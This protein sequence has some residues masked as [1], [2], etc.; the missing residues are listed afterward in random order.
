MFVFNV[1]F[2]K[3]NVFNQSCEQLNRKK[4]TWNKFVNKKY[5]KTHFYTLIK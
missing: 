4:R 2:V 5:F 1:A 3:F